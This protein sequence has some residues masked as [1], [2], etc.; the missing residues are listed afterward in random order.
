MYSSRG[1]AA[2]FERLGN[3]ENHTLTFTQW[4]SDPWQ[5]SYMSA[6][7]KKKENN[8]SILCMVGSDHVCWTL[9]CLTKGSFL[10]VLLCL[11]AIC[12]FFF[13]RKLHSWHQWDCFLSISQILG[14]LG[15]LT[16]IK[17][18]SH[19]LATV[20]SI[21]LWLNYKREAGRLIFL[22]TQ[23]VL[24]IPADVCVVW[25]DHVTLTTKN[26]PVFRAGWFLHLFGFYEHN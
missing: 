26:I 7:L 24:Q 12:W 21:P 23:C 4:V 1:Q 19:T 14:F 9:L 10:I 16:Y 15:L 22:G 6:T 18:L 5:Q 25:G 3:L 17:T 13:V 8:S 2:D 11:T 20:T